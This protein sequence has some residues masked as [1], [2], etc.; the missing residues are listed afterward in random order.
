MPV[1]FDEKQV[2]PPASTASDVEESART[3]QFFA[4][5]TRGVPVTD[6]G[7]GVGRWERNEQTAESEEC[8]DQ[9]PG[10]G[11]AL[12]MRFRAVH[13][14]SQNFASSEVLQVRVS[15]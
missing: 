12:A 10:N 7:S 4:D 8:K 3:T 5:R 2:T 13:Q 14:K 15:C 11:N 9:P 1:T 6:Q